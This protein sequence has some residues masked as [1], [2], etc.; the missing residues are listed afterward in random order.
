MAG[1]V[2][3]HFTL[4]GVEKDK[5]DDKELL[6]LT[7]GGQ[8]ITKCRAKFYALLELLMKIASL[9]TQFYTLDE[10]LKVTRRRVNALDQVV[11][12]NIVDTID[13]IKSE[14]D[15]QDREDFFRLKRVQDKKKIEKEQKLR[16]KELAEREGNQEENNTAEN[17]IF[18]EEEDEDIVF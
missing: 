14:L 9:Q 16:E 11:I 8:A 12:P 1:V 7:G 6:G 3:P 5:L 13:Y 18:E 4:R 10:A 2:L 17:A 15:E